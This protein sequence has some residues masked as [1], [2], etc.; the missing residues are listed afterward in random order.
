MSSYQPA[1][2]WLPTAGAAPTAIAA[3]A[4]TGAA[5]L[6]FGTGFVH[7]ERAASQ[8]GAIEGSDCFITL[9]GVRHFYET[10]TAGAA[11]VAVGHDADAIHL[12]VGFEEAAQFFFARIEVEVPNKNVFHTML[13][14]MSYLS[15]G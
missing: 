15:V 8:L 1:N 5:T 2:R 14:G 10:E 4:S 6:G 12:A 13:L 11:C 9:F 7:V 3:S